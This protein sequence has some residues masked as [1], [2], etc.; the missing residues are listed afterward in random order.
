ML[1]YL[2]QACSLSADV[3]DQGGRTPLHLVCEHGHVDAFEYLVR[4]EVSYPPP[5]RTQMFNS[6][7][8]VPR[9]LAN[10]AAP[11]HDPT[12]GPLSVAPGGK[13]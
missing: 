5:S 7:Y 3:Q 4:K 1:H 8:P 2:L 12:W 10:M 6:A 9:Q 11:I 13:Y